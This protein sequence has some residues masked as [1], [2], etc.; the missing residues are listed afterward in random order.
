MK[1]ILLIEDDSNYIWHIKNFLQRKGYHVLVAFTVYTRKRAYRKGTNTHYRLGFEI[2]RW[3]WNGAA[4]ILA[5]ENIQNSIP[6]LY[7][8]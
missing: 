4:R 2:V 7:M 8:L 5:G 1:K 6:F 3:E